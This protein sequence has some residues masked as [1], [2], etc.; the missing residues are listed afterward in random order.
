M[1][2]DVTRADAGEILCQTSDERSYTRT[3]VHVDVESAHIHLSPQDQIINTLGEKVQLKCEITQPVESAKWYRNGVEV[4]EHSG[5]HFA[6]NEDKILLLEIINFDE[7]D[8]GN[9]A[10]ELPNGER[11]APANIRLKITP[12]IELSREVRPDSEVLLRA[13]DDLVFTVSVSV[14]YLPTT[15]VLC[16]RNKLLV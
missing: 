8:V 11:S 16:R 9:Y 4:Y 15:S 5:K 2:K 14:A 10:V 13:G 7:K 12:H 1:I 3:R 6:F